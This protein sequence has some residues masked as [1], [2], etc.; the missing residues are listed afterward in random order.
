MRTSRQFRD[1]YWAPLL[2][3]SYTSGI[4]GNCLI[5]WEAHDLSP[6]AMWRKVQC[7]QNV[8][9]CQISIGSLVLINIAFVKKGRKANVESDHF[10]SLVPR[11]EASIIVLMLEDSVKVSGPGRQRWSSPRTQA[12]AIDH[13][14]LVRVIPLACVQHA[15]I[16]KALLYLWLYLLPAATPCEYKDFYKRV[17]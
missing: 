3:V 6:Q 10:Q 12:E 1:A 16:L 11:K 13:Y 5:S 4:R 8:I 7:L 15:T 9:S 17:N 14:L 2:S